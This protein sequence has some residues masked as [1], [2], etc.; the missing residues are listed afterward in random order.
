MAHAQAPHDQLDRVGQLLLHE[1]EAFLGL[2]VDPDVDAA[3]PDADREQ[4]SDRQDRLGQQRHQNERHHDHQEHHT[5][6]HAGRERQVRL[7]RLFG[8][9]R[10]ERDRLGPVVLRHLLA[11]LRHDLVARRALLEQREA[12]VDTVVE[13]DR[14]AEDQHVDAADRQEH[15]TEDGDVDQWLDGEFH[16]SGSLPVR[17]SRRAGRS[18]TT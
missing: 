1:G 2:A 17:R 10:V 14:F 12:A 7:L 3:D 8:Q 11:E 5:H 16:V 15:G 6:E 18:P 4:S 13:L 9:Q